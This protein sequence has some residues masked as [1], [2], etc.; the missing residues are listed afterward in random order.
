M[1]TADKIT[2]IHCLA[3]DF[4]KLNMPVC[5]FN[6]TFEMITWLME[7]NILGLITYATRS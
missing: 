5:F 4:F 2:E 1:F 6:I 7:V 3:D